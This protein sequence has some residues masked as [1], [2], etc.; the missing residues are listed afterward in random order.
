MHGTVNTVQKVSVCGQT[1]NSM[2][3]GVRTETH[4]INESCCVFLQSKLA[5]VQQTSCF[6]LKVAWTIPQKCPKELHFTWCLCSPWCRQ[7]WNVL[8]LRARFILANG[9]SWLLQC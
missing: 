8:P 9:K 6:Y 2:I 3:D 4:E 7:F 5:Q 1:I